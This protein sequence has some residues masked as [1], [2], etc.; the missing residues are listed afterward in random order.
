MTKYVGSFSFVA[1]WYAN[2]H[3]FINKIKRK[4]RGKAEL[5]VWIKDL[6]GTSVRVGGISLAYSSK[7]Y[8]MEM[9]YGTSNM[10][11]AVL[12]A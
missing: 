1:P 5:H 8:K 11:I 10:Q 3:L 6:K 12:K 2:S 7:M 4:L 9:F